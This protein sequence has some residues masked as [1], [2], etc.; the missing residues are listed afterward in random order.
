MAK[1][2]PPKNIEAQEV[3]AITFQ[4]PGENLSSVI[5]GAPVDFSVE[6]AV[7]F[8]LFKQ[9]RPWGFR[10]KHFREWYEEFED[11]LTEVKPI[12]VRKGER[13]NPIKPLAPEPPEEETKPAKKAAKKVVGTGKRAA[14]KKKR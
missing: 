12:K 5:E 4:V 8:R 10:V 2:K 9:I 14:A 3:Y 13:L 6:Q 1:A 7:L 11:A